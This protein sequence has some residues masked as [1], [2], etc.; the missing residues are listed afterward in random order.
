MP[1]LSSEISDGEDSR[2]LVKGRR[3]TIFRQK[4]LWRL[5]DLSLSLSLPSFDFRINGFISLLNSSKKV[6]I[7]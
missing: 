6:E 5:P 1:T 4:N 3:I 7:R 2:W